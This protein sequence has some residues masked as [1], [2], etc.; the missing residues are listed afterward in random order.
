M[1]FDWNRS[2]NGALHRQQKSSS[3]LIPVMPAGLLSIHS[4][5]LAI[6]SKCG[7][8]DA[9]VIFI[10]DFWDFTT[11]LVAQRVESL[12]FHSGGFR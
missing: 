11:A 4:D 12:D 8:T 9:H 7:F 5:E 2:N 3:V 10:V 1:G 6:L